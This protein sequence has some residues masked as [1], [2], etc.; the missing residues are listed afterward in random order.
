MEKG[1]FSEEAVISGNLKWLTSTSRVDQLYE[2]EDEVRSPFSRDYNRILHSKAYRRLKHKT[3]VFYATSNDHV[4]TRIEHVNHVASVS[5]TIAKFLG[6]N[7]ELT[8]AISI[9][10]DLGH[11]PFGHF[12]EQILRKISKN[13][14]GEAFWHEK[15][16]LHFVDDL[17][18]LPNP[19]GKEKN[20]S[21]TY[22]VRD[23]IISHCGEVNEN[24]I[25]P[26]N[27]AVDLHLIKKPNEYSPFTWEAC[28]VKISDKIS[29]LG[30]DI[31][32]ALTLKI[33]SREQIEELI[34]IVEKIK[35][36]KVSQINN[37][38]LM[39]DFVNN[40]C[41]MS[42]PQ[43]GILFSDK[44]LDLINSVKKF[45]YSNIYDHPRLKHYNKFA[46]LVIT[47]TYEVLT[48]LFVDKNSLKKNLDEMEAIYPSLIGSF[49][50][51]LNKYSN[52][53]TD[54]REE[55]KFA[56]K[57]IYDINIEK[58]YKT[59]VIDYIS[60]MTDNFALKIFSELTRFE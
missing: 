3:Q 27:D 39:H 20:L 47:S 8:A 46:D 60:S 51:W 24:A 48:S 13:E 50:Y 22:A 44:Y 33:L 36:V 38:V 17:E 49:Y 52:I 54:G 59:A 40:L 4:C 57:I 2:R 58:E 55:T 37:T 42:S 10:H 15:N 1:K 21:L 28:V 29:Y 45:N 26:R 56:N 23:G 12:G 6:L 11:S 53:Y 7:T 41:Q 14:I 5:Y 34:S 18:T 35:K 32:D 31:E 9:G 43:D 25:F 16:S 30:R 19:E